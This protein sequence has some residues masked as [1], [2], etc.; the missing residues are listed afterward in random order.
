MRENIV[1]ALTLIAAIVTVTAYARSSSS[2]AEAAPKTKKT[3]TVEPSGDESGCLD[4]NEIA[5]YSEEGG[6]K[7]ILSPGTYYIN[8]QLRLNSNT[9]LK[10]DGAKIIE[11]Q[12]GSR[13]ITQPYDRNGYKQ[14][15]GYD[16]VH[17]ITIDGGTWAG[18]KKFADYGV[19]IKNGQKTGPN[20]INFWHARNITIKNLC[21]YNA[22]NAH[23]IEL[24]GVKN[25]RIIGCHIGCRKTKDGSLKRG[26]SKGDIYRG[27]IQLDFCSKSGNRHSEPF[28][29]TTCRNVTIKDNY[30]WYRT[31]IQIAND[32]SKTTNDVKVK[33]NIL[34]CKY[35]WTNVSMRKA[36]GFKESGNKRKKY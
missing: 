1:K 33:D 11:V 8:G 15:K 10:A 29:G 24:C 22:V 30:I 27:A 28:D 32:S 20:V 4:F 25:A 23:L 18:T 26:C 17:D 12:N 14:R 2:M 6:Y 5:A 7:I 34:R 3:V 9:Y 19:N 36:R 16:S 21:V 13:L 35:A 31:G